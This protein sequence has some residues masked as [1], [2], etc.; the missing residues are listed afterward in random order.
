MKKSRQPRKNSIKKGF[1]VSKKEFHKTQQQFT[2]LE[3][4]ILIEG[5]DNS[6]TG[7]EAL[8]TAG[9][10]LAAK[11][12]DT[13]VHICEQLLEHFDLVVDVHIMYIRALIALE[14]SLSVDRQLNY[15]LKQAPDNPG[16]QVLAA[17]HYL[18]LGDAIRAR[19]F[20]NQARMSNPDSLEVMLQL[21]ESYRLTNDSDRVKVLANKILELIDK[22]GDFRDDNLIGCL[23]SLH[24]LGM[25]SS[26]Y[27]NYLQE[28][29]DDESL[30]LSARSTIALNFSSAA[31]NAGEKAEEVKYLE[32]A[33][34]LSLQE[35]WGEESVDGYVSRLNKKFIAHDQFARKIIENRT[36]FDARLSPIFIMGLPRSG[37]TLLEQ[38]LGS[39]SEIGQVG[40]SKAT[41]IAINRA[42]KST[43]G[44]FTVDDYP[45]NADRFDD[46]TLERIMVNISDYQKLIASDTSFLD[47]E[48]SNFEY[49][50]L[51]K[52]LF[53]KARFVHV[54]RNPLDTF[55]SCYRGSIPGI[56]STC[57]L[58][59]LP[60]YYEYV[61][62]MIGLWV[63]HYSDSVYV[64]RYRDLVENPEVTLKSVTQFLGLDWQPQ[65]LRFNERSNVVRTLSVNQV[66]KGLYTSSIDAWKKYE[67]LLTPSIERL[68]A[69]GLSLDGVDY[70]KF[71]S[72][73]FD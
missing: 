56:P 58:K 49:V 25:L 60:L 67:D 39:H 61:K 51:T 7:L 14:D 40:E 66:K 5:R 33:N 26:H 63:H 27:Q 17:R 69:R 46:E 1:G 2:N 12:F 42:Y 6:L 21:L 22:M 65:M 71:D 52:K 38:M 73:E 36:D 59:R 53:P 47:K 44:I 8:R 16:L 37:T 3:R 30:D 4:H 28:R 20:L 43:T 57:C 31:K 48:L 55:L 13:C 10:F 35:H 11:R 62:K 24:R 29:L 18:I 72:T 19:H 41:K 32:L 45:L 50:A 15:L 23:T 34:R 68:E 54:A 64:V 70:I 9:K